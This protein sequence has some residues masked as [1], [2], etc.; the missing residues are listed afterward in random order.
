MLYWNW[1]YECPLQE[2]ERERDGLFSELG[3]LL[4]PDVVVSDNE[5]NNRVERTHGDSSVRHKLS[6]VDLIEMVDAVDL[7]R[8]SIVSGSRYIHS[9]ME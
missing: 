9:N 4:H 1:N 2:F 5:D 7:H 6:H 8:G 3:N